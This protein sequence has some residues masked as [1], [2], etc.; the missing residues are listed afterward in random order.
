MWI[1]ET[2]EEIVRAVNSGGLTESAIFDAKQDLSAN[3]EIAKDI[4]AMT[5]D[6]GS[7]IY[8]IGEDEHGHLTVLN[9]IDVAGQKERI[10]SI[11]QTSISEPPEVRIVL[12]PTEADPSKGYL[13]VRVP[14]SPR[15]PHMVIV[16]GENRFYSRGPAGNVRLNE[17]DVARLYEGRHRLE[18]DR[19]NLLDEVISRAPI[20]QHDEYGY[21]HLVAKPL[22]TNAA[23]LDTARQDKNEQDFL[24]ELF[25]AVR[26]SAHQYF[27]NFSHIPFWHMR[28][29]GWFAFLGEDVRSNPGRDPLE[30]LDMS[31]EF[32]GTGYLFCGSVARKTPTLRSGEELV[33]LDRYIADL[34]TRFI[35]MMAKLYDSAHYLGS[36]TLGIAV[37][38][39]EGGISVERAKGIGGGAP[40][41]FDRSDYR[42]TIQVLA[43]SL[44]DDPV[45]AAR[46]LVLPLVRAT[47]QWKDWDPFQ[48]AN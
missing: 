17:G 25:K 26:Q 22:M 6:G 43:M 3:R 4:C 8:G 30:V 31:I 2:E 39:I 9:P 28:T 10:A 40:L 14:P 38:G 33:I 7:I 19:Q 35:S 5:V 23:F 37:T 18:S 45:A 27:P 36:V 21:L 13:V 20:L 11:V 32:D 16:G 48:Q 34:T 42:L 1:P 24:V 29:S 47:T 44:V 46:S 41:P 15:V 12:I